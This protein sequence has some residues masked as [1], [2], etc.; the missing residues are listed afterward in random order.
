[1]TSCLE[2]RGMSTQDGRHDVIIR[3]SLPQ[4]DLTAHSDLRVNEER[5]QSTFH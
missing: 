3:R 5:R 2:L 4:G 1:M